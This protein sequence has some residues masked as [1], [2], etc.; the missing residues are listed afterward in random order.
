MECSQVQEK[1]SA[2]LDGA[3]DEATL[4]AVEAHLDHCAECGE[5]LEA[6][7]V[8]VELMSG[9]C[10]VDP[11]AYLRD[12]IRASTPL[13]VAQEA[14]SCEEYVA[15][16]SAYVDGELSASER[17]AVEAHVGECQVCARELLVLRST[18]ASMG[19]VREVAPPAALRGRIAA[20]TTGRKRLAPIGILRRY[21]E[22]LAIPRFGW[23][24][25]MAAAAACFVGIVLVT[26][27]QPSAPTK[28]AVKTDRPALVVV[29]APKV[30]RT[31]EAETSPTPV[32]TE[33][34]KAV[35]RHRR[36]KVAVVPRS[37]KRVAA[38]KRV[39]AS[40]K[41]KHPTALPVKPAASTVDEIA[42]NISVDEG[43]LTVADKPSTEAPIEIAEAPKST[44]MKLTLSSVMTAKDVDQY[45]KEIKL[46]IQTKE[47]SSDGIRVDVISKRF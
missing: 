26:S 27:H 43:M 42:D 37:E 16:L 33:I 19:L 29:E 10:E 7:R 25:G 32:Q 21:V 20:A 12:A 46:D 28:V 13:S 35:V 11:P 14:E 38:S 9:V 31:L 45:F 8:V 36:V 22:G 40:S 4:E 39:I 47:R 30:A 2:F 3:L 34:P 41:V 44:V 6:L 17:E 1:L 23:A 18:V 15:M 24:A 5:E